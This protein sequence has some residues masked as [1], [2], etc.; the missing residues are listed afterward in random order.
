MKLVSVVFTIDG[1]TDT[2]PPCTLFTGTIQLRVAQAIA[3]DLHLTE[4]L[5]ALHLLLALISK[6]AATHDIPLQDLPTLGDLVPLLSP[7]ASPPTTPPTTP[8]STP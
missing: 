1:D 6:L 7:P 4:P 2:V 5:P 8:P 3:R